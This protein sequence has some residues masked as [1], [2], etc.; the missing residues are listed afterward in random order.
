[1]RSEEEKM[2]REMEERV[3]RVEV[4]QRRRGEEEE[5]KRRREEEE[6]NKKT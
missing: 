4:C 6:N 2:V 5:K 3:E 1:M